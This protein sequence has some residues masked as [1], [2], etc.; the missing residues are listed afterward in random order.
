MNPESGT[1]AIVCDQPMTRAGLEQ[2]VNGCPGLIVGASVSTAE[3]LG[4]AEPRDYRVVILDLPAL[5][6]RPATDVIGRLA[7]VGATLVSSSW[8]RPPTLGAAMRAGARGVIT[9][10]TARLALRQAVLTVAEG[11]LSVATELT[12]RFLAEMGRPADTG[13]GGLAPREAETLRWIALG[14]THS[15]IATRMGLSQATVNTYAKRI[16]AK[17]NVS[18]KAELTRVAI[19]LGHLAQGQSRYATR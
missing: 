2:L 11:G 18:N 12:D 16:R 15:Q 19:E 9:R 4:R 5:P 17:L 13:D 7:A 1:V 10:Y 3:D 14:F 6:H 8:D